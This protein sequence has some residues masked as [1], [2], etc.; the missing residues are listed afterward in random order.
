MDRL[1]LYVLLIAFLG[2]RSYVFWITNLFDNRM[3]TAER[4]SALRKL[5]LLLLYKKLK[6]RRSGK[7][8]DTDSVLSGG[9][10]LREILEGNTHYREILCMDKE[11][12]IA[13]YANFKKR[14]AK[15]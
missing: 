8:P 4:R 12:F 15:E 13:L 7:R 9:Q 14:P 2:L 11:A 3:L 5:A 1:F 6:R 10:Y